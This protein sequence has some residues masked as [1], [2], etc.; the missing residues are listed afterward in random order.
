MAEL[1][2][3]QQH[4]TTEDHWV[5]EDTFG[6]RLALVRQHFGWNVKKAAD[7]CGI[8]VQ[9]WRSWES[10]RLPRNLY[11]VVTT[12]AERTGVDRTWLLGGGPLRSRCL[13]P[14]HDYLGQLVLFND[15]GI[16]WDHRPS[17][18]AVNES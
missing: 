12:I 8:P 9:N 4:P 1:V 3:P 2:Q 17:L 7:C 11:D 6:A 10:G 5:P 15:D 16:G 18:A 14:M 13:S